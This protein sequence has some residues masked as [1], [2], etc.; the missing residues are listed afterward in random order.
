MRSSLGK[1]VVEFQHRR[2]FEDG[3]QIDPQ[4]PQ[5]AAMSLQGWLVG[6]FLIKHKNTGVVDG[7]MHAIGV[8]PRFLPHPGHD[9][10]HHR[11]E[12]LLFAGLYGQFGGERQP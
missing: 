12:R 6:V 1:F 9:A 7:A 11:L 4:L 8:I 10:A 2:A 5:M 3:S